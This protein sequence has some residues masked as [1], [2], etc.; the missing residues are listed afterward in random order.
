M[1]SPLHTKV[2][3]QVRRT[4]LSN[5]ERRHLTFCM[6]RIMFSCQPQ[7][8][9]LHI[10]RLT[11]THFYVSDTAEICKELMRYGYRGIFIYYPGKTVRFFKSPFP[12]RGLIVVVLISLAQIY[13]VWVTF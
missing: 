4:P 1:C 8:E 7:K 10:P 3:Q 9:K 12:N 11:V 6:M 5:S 2:S 13:W